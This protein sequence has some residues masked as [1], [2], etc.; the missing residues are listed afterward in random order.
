MWETTKARGG[1]R[2]RGPWLLARL[3]VRGKCEAWCVL[4]FSV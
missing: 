4:V 2:S 3:W 1:T